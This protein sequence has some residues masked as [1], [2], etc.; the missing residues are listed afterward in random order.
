MGGFITENGADSFR[1]VA[2]YRLSKDDGNGHESDSIVNQR[3]LIREYIK[4]HPNITLVGEEQDDGYTGTNFDRPGFCRVLEIV[5]AGEA[6]CVIVKDL[7]RLGREYIETGKYLEMTF[8]A[9]GVRFI[10][11]NDDIDS[12]HRGSGDDIIIPVKNIMNE[13][14]CRELSKKL[15]RQFKIQ[16]MNG[17]FMGAF[18][19][20]GYNKSP[21]DK[22]KLVPDEFA[23]EVVKIIFSLKARGFSQQ[24]IAN[25]LNSEG[26]L[27]PAEYKKSRGF[28]YKSGFSSASTGIWTAGTVRAIL[29]NP[30]YTGTLIQ[31]KRG[32]PNYKIKKMKSKNP[33]EWAVVE[34]NHEPIVDPLLFSAVQK[35]LGRDTR[36]SP[37]L[38]GV[39][40]LAGML[41]C[42]DCGRAMCRRSVN[43]SGK[44]FYYYICS[45]SKGG[46]ECSSHS[47]EQGK[48]EKAV[49][50][51]VIGRI[52]AVVEV[53]KLLEE[54]GQKNIA[55]AKVKGLDLLIAD[56]TANIEKNKTFR[57][58]LYEAYTDDLISREEYERMREKYSAQIED[59][60]LVVE[61]AESEKREAM[62]GKERDRGWI[63][64]FLRFDGAEKLT[65][66][67]VFTLIDRIYVYED[68]RI[69]I[70][71]NYC[72]EFAASVELAQKSK[73]VG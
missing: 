59:D 20:Y 43:R 31:G 67:M 42:G 33:S 71:F 32:T 52:K 25:F 38:D 13:A 41:F 1:A 24:R 8:P 7:S 34:N 21:E 14:Y 12:E 36:T 53:D 50:H 26:I 40:P 39:L 57:M 73:E 29:I 11:I 56:K 35:V 58:K 72:D 55:S 63:E 28:N 18:A 27:P 62:G 51:A 45:T 9:L 69:K 3:K 16:R 64:Q 5:K 23:A 2:Y 68:K 6:N 60:T 49:L 66:E 47:F 46:G 19:C 4:N 54:Y 17:E 30:V 10:A 61:K 37:T 22:H 15:R 65:R 44:K 48:L 70:I